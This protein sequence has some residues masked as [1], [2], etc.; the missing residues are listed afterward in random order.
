MGGVFVKTINPNGAAAFDGRLGIGDRIL[1]V[2][3]V[4][5]SCATRQQV[6][7]NHSLSKRNRAASVRCA[8]LADETNS[9][10]I[11][12]LFVHKYAYVKMIVNID[13]GKPLFSHNSC[14]TKYS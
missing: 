12:V 11:D 1:E 4:N 3:D 13:S 14:N 5:L 8:V 9:V 7:A 6:I 2:N 10:S